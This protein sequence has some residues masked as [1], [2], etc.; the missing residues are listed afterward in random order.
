MNNKAKIP[1]KQKR[2]IEKTMKKEINYPLSLPKKTMKKL[3]NSVETINQLA[4]NV[5]PRIVQS[6]VNY[7]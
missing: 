3:T 1:L 7:N 2:T 6:I 4:S 5:L